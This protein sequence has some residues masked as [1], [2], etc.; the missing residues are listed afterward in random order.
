MEF[1][2]GVVCLNYYSKSFLKVAGQL[3]SFVSL[4]GKQDFYLYSFAINIYIS[5]T[6]LHIRFLKQLFSAEESDGRITDL[7]CSVSSCGFCSIAE[8]I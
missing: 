1:L 3:D 2:G 4:S 6:L 8:E 7:I 5:Q